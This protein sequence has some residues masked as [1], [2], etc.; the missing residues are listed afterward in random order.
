MRFSKKASP[1]AVSGGVT[2]VSAAAT[3]AAPAPMAS[4][5]AACHLNH[6]K[7]DVEQRE[8]NLERDLGLHVQAGRRQAETRF[9]GLV[10]TGPKVM[11]P[12]VY[13]QSP[14]PNPQSP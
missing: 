14:I 2:V 10:V 1:A 7:T 9:R 11:S 3:P 8:P 6:A 13:R 12:T 5:I 4:A